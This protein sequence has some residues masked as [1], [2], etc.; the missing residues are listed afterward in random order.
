ML[1]N[2]L[3]DKQKHC[4]TEAHTATQTSNPILFGRKSMR[5]KHF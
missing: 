2:I 5:H 1:V 4:Y 3:L